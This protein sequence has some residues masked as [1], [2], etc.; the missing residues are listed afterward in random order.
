[1]A[2]LSDLAGPLEGG[3][4]ELVAALFVRGLDF[5][6]WVSVVLYARCALPDPAQKK[7]Y[8]VSVAP[9]RVLCLH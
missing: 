8:Q 9:G 3:A 1:M 2:S 4:A 6:F 7:W 5:W